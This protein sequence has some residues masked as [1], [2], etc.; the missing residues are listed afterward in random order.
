MS[1]EIAA[2]I[3]T[4]AGGFFASIGTLA[5]TR[6]MEQR[7]LEVISPSRRDGLIGKWEGVVHQDGEPG[8]KPLDFPLNVTIEKVG[9]KVVK[10]TSHF[11]LIVENEAP[12]GADLSL[13]GGFIPDRFLTL[14]Y[15]NK[16]KAQQFGYLILELS[17]DGNQLEGRFV[18]YG[19]RAKKLVHGTVE[20]M[21]Q[22]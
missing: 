7:H 10:G 13:Y 3:I 21:H 14:N 22:N 1:N 19:P 20:L 8:Q 11:S 18:G 6:A 16:E 5:V 2:A 9:R 12:R 15:M 4:V 17:P